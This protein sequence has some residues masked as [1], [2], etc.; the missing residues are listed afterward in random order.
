MRFTVWKPFLIMAA[1]AP[2]AVAIPPCQL[3]DAYASG[4]SVWLLCRDGGI[5][6]TDDLGAT[7]RRQ[8][9]KAGTRLKAVV[10][11][12]SRRGF[13]LGDSGAVLATED[14]GSN[15]RQVSVPAQERLMA[16][17]FTGESGWSVGWGGAIVHTAD[18][19]RTW[20]RQQSGTT[21]SLE[22]VYFAD[23]EHGWA[24]GWVGTILR[25]VNGGRTWQAAQSSPGQWSLNAVYFRNNQEGWAVGFVGQILRSRD[26]GATWEAQNAGVNSSLSSVL[27]DS[28]NR[29]WITSDDGF[30][31]SEDSGQT[32]KAVPVAG[33]LFLNRLL[34]VGGSLWAVGPF[35][36]LKQTGAGLDWQEIQ[37]FGS[38]APSSGQRASAQNPTEP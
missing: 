10:F 8:A 11:L 9:V 16:V 23:A 18:G 29:C 17:H 6:R 13:V 25:T 14:G 12:D 37:D 35:G 3:Q 2:L 5:L 1:C 20:E 31:V 26:G 27:F 24:V 22:D 15:W 33:R 36:V 38:G 19:G 4:K 7:W 34:A 30:L 21:Q 28:S 32:W